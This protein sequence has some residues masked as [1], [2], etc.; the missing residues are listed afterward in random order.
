MNTDMF[1]AFLPGTPL[2]FDGP[3]MELDLINPNLSEIMDLNTLLADAQEILSGMPGGNGLEPPPPG[4]DQTQPIL[5]TPEQTD[6]AMPSDGLVEGDK[7]CASAWA[8]LSKYP[9]Y[10][11]ASL[12]FPSKY[13]VRRFVKAFFKHIAAHIPVVHELTFE[14]AT[15]P[16]KYDAG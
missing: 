2:T 16:C 4:L 6:E 11:L 1:S 13:A 7:E 8:N 3:L 15:A 5:P 12:R 9:V 14:I 10:I